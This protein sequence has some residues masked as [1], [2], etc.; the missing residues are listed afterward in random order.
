[1]SWNDDHYVKD[2]VGNY[3]SPEELERAY[4][5]GNLERLSSGRYY[6]RETGEEYWED[7][8]VKK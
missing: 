1:M 8:V 5:D 3:E 2:E 7:G 6:D 4:R